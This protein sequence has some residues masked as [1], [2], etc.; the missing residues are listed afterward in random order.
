[1]PDAALPNRRTLPV[2]IRARHCWRAMRERVHFQIK[3]PVVSIRA[4]HCWRAMRTSK[5][6]TRQT[7]TFQ[8]APA[9]AGGRCGRRR[10]GYSGRASF[11]PRPP[12]LAGDAVVLLL[13]ILE[14][15]FQSAPAIA[16]GR[17]HVRSLARQQGG[18]FNPRPPLLAGDARR[19]GRVQVEASV[20]I[21]ARHCWRAMRAYAL[22]CRRAPTSFNPRPPLLAGDAVGGWGCRFAPSGFNPRPPLLAGDAPRC[23]GIA[24]SSL[25]PYRARTPAAPSKGQTKI[26]CEKEKPFGNNT[27]RS[28]RTCLMQRHHFRFAALTIAWHPCPTAPAAHQNPRP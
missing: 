9:I 25:F 6:S 21:R 15:V 18:S 22:H 19:H 12:L 5:P 8:S 1:M 11:N 23:Q 13:Q 27:L 3:P 10:D 28:A 26:A 14:Q 16:G 17:C 7:S 24:N 4:R 20:S 2:S